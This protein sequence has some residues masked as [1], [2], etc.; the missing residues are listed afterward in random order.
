MIYE[1]RGCAFAVVFSAVVAEDLWSEEEEALNFK[2]LLLLTLTLCL[3][4]AKFCVHACMT[5]EFS[6]RTK[7]LYF[8]LAKWA[9][10]VRFFMP[11]L[12]ARQEVAEET[13]FRQAE[14]ASLLVR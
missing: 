13:R 11:L 5:P 6:G 9:F 14:I 8:A 3:R 1:D 10:A 7:L 12:A 2:R 4:H